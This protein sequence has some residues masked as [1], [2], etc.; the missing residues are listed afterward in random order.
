MEVTII[1]K[2]EAPLRLSP[3]A[4]CVSYPDLRG[5]INLVCG[6][7]FGAVARFGGVTV[8]ATRPMPG[9]KVGGTC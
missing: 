9:S 3:A 8:A 4:A 5:P 1:F 7:G 2:G 6:L